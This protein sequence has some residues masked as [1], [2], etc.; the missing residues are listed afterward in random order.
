MQSDPSRAQFECQP[1]S[2]VQQRRIR[3][4][5]RDGTR[6]PGRGPYRVIVCDIPWAYEIRAED[7]SHR[8]THPYPTMN[9]EQAC[10]F[11]LASIA[12]DNCIL[13]FWTVNFYMREVYQV[14]DILTWAKDRMGMGDWLRG[15]TE[16]CI[17]AVRGK[18]VHM[19]TNQS[20][21][22]NAPVRGHSQKP[23]EFYDMVEALCPA[24]RYADVFSRYRH[25]AK[26]DCHGNEAPVDP[27]Q[28]A[29]A[30]QGLACQVGR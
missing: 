15:Q 4:E 16:H 25:N 13:W 12:A 18:P 5:T 9:I 1:N 30:Q 29:K 19:L 11:P 21:L 28:P 2:A 20:T 27:D 10:A 17:M 22:L 24:P 6:L 14:L 26:W 23:F 7:P 3:V 8:G